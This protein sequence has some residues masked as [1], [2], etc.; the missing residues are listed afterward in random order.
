MPFAGERVKVLRGRPVPGQGR[1]GEVLEVGDEG[2][3][4]AATEG[5]YR[6][7]EVQ[8]P[9]KRPEAARSL[10]GHRRAG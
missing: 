4:V 8:V 6:L 9:G 7:E 10:V 2:V 1:P 3:V 5:A